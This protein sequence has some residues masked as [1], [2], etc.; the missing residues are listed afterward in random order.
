MSQKDKKEKRASR[1]SRRQAETRKS[2]LD[3]ARKVFAV[4]GLTSATIAQITET[5]DLGFGTFYLHFASKEELY[6]AVLKE[7]FAELDKELKQILDEAR[8]SQYSGNE[9]IEIVIAIFFRFA[10]ENRDLFQVGFAGLD[11]GMQIGISLRKQYADWFSELLKEIH[12]VEIPESQLELLSTSIV[13]MVSRTAVWWMQQKEESEPDFLSLE[14]AIA[15]VSRFA[16][17]GLTDFYS[18]SN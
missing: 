2:L 7:G 5:A 1:K 12:P 4:T 18:I 11:A 15:V 14:Q 13:A 6:L 17:A 9:I 8:E 10:R 16:I 3:A